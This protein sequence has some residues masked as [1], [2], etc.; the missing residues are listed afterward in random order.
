[1]VQM[2]DS[3]FS[4]Y[5]EQ[6]LKK[7]SKII[8]KTLGELPVISVFKKRLDAAKKARNQRKNV[9]QSKSRQKSPRKRKNVN[10]C[11]I[12]KHQHRLVEHYSQIVSNL[13]S[14]R[15]LKT[16]SFGMQKLS[17]ILFVCRQWDFNGFLRFLGSLGVYRAKRTGANARH[18]DPHGVLIRLYFPYHG[19]YATAIPIRGRSLLFQSDEWSHF[20]IRL[21][22]DQGPRFADDP[23]RREW[24]FVLF[25]V[26][27]CKRINSNYLAI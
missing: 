20:G 18:A 23:S 17:S 15:S 27:P 2:I 13:H 1:M 10:N 19:D 26:C 9:T 6:T 16:R 22:Y 21:R 14:N 25:H 3:N 7:I 12:K 5:A 4:Y 8:D 24:R 11:I